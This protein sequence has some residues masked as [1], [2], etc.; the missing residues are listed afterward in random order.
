MHRFYTEKNNITDTEIVIRGEDVHHITNVLRMKTGAEINICDGDSKE[1]TC[2]ISEMSKDE[3]RC[4]VKSLRILD[5]EPETSITLFQSLPKL[6]K[7]EM[8]IQK[9]VELGA[10]CVVPV[11]SSRCVARPGKNYQEKLRRFNKIACEA[12]KQSRRGILPSVQPPVAIEQADTLGYDLI[13]VAYEDENKTTLSLALKKCANFP[14]KIALFIG[15]EGG[16]EQNEV[17]LLTAK[18]AVPVS[19]GKRILRTETAGIAAIA[20]ILF[21]AEDKK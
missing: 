5:T 19:L 3:I 13:L 18:G 9:C 21:A 2:V 4:S 16:Y 12:A 8:I 1:Y 10:V 7:F 20:M 11:I 6:D 15:P 14:K 17:E